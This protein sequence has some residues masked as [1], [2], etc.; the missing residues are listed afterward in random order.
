[1]RGLLRHLHHR[2]C[3]SHSFHHTLQLWTK[4]LCQRLL[5]PSLFRTHRLVL[6]RGLHQLYSGHSSLCRDCHHFGLQLEWSEDYQA[7]RCID[8]VFAEH[9]QNRGDLDCWDCDNSERGRQS[10][11]PAWVQRRDSKCGEGRRVWLH[12]VGYPD[13]QQTHFQEVFR[14]L[15]IKGITKHHIGQQSRFIKR[16]G[17]ANW[18]NHLIHLI[19]SAYSASTDHLSSSQGARRNCHIAHSHCKLTVNW[20]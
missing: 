9:N 5:W 15:G 1:M 8:S 16:E 2:T 3:S 20:S 11:L 12:S 4:T 19:L 18:H 6:P 10:R 13:L 17:L 7:Y 14:P